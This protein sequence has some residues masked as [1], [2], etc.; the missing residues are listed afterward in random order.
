LLAE[1]QR[2]HYPVREEQLRAGK[3]QLLNAGPPPDLRELFASAQP[4]EPKSE[5]GVALVIV[6][7]AVEMFAD[8]VELAKLA[9]TPVGISADTER[10]VLDVLLKNGVFGEPIQHAVEDFAKRYEAVKGRGVSAVFGAVFGGVHA[11]FV[12]A[13]GRIEQDRKSHVDLLASPHP[14]DQFPVRGSAEVK[15]PGSLW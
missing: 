9:L 12:D 8:N 10:D 5:A 4:P 1:T 14:I 7:N 13:I 3:P 11:N 15:G 6:A 2:S